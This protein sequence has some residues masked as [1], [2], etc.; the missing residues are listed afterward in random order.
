[1]VR[2]I[3]QRPATNRGNVKTVPDGSD[4]TQRTPKP[5]VKHTDS[6]ARF[7]ELYEQYF[8]F[9]WRT[10]RFLGAPTEATDDAVQDVFLVAHR[11]LEDF[12]ARATPRTWLFAIAL[13]VVKDH[14]RSR[15]RRLRLL[16]QARSIERSFSATPFD[17]RVSAEMLQR[18][19]AALDQLREDQRMVFVLAE[20]EE[21]S[22]P[23]IAASLHMN[24][25]TVYSR[26]RV[27][28]QEMARILN[29][30]ATENGR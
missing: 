6:A 30:S 17:R 5:E 27:A 26:L 28:R 3:F 8:S 14:R 23:E 22:A 10:V 25:N 19:T 1:M 2:R 20:L 21:M 15:R 7:T 16:D 29:Q 24:L 9:V 18:L 13:R 4:R 11:R 12:E